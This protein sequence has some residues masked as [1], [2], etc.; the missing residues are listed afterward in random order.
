MNR[1]AIIASIGLCACN[2]TTFDDLAD[3]TWVDSTGGPDNASPAEYG[4]SM[5]PVGVSTGAA[6][7][8]SMRSPDGVA[9]LTYD[10]TGAGAVTSTEV[11]ALVPNAAQLP[12][13]PILAADPNSDRVL[14]ATPVGEE[15]PP[16]MTQLLVY[17]G[18]TLSG[19]TTVTLSA[20]GHVGALAVGDTDV[21]PDTSG[22]DVV[23][24]VDDTLIVVDDYQM[25]KTQSDC[26]LSREVAFAGLVGDF[27][28]AGAS[29]EVVLAL[30]NE[31]R[32]GAASSIE[33][34]SAST[35]AD[36]AMIASGEPCF[37][38]IAPLRAPLLSIPAP[39]D[40][41]DFGVS[42][43]AGDFTGDGN[44]DLAA[45]APGTNKVY[46]FTA[47]DLAGG[48]FGTPVE[49]PVPAGSGVFGET[50]AAGDLDG[51]GADE[52]IVGDS[53]A[54]SG[55]EPN[56]GAA[57]IFVFDGDDPGQP[58]T[59]HDAQPEAEQRFGRALAVGT[60]EGTGLLSVGADGEVFTYFRT[61]VPGDTDPR[62]GAE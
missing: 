45:G 47:I 28:A 39:G 6:F 38:D 44:L 3:Q 30:G 27:G 48:S 54:A 8:V 19:P 61:P 4:L 35:V 11:T 40:E 62:P 14:L 15:V 29:A 43:V 12:E 36:A 41:G 57:H 2:W 26:V 24:T 1:L 49:L 17:S 59:L 9:L 25:T 33:I 50:L 31:A 10:Q 16:A 21:D 23:V 56:A 58:L 42:L 32:S 20:E 18:A 46:V 22:T 5:A 51:D 52:L 60:F 55:G 53:R 34:F 13:R 37:T 7:L